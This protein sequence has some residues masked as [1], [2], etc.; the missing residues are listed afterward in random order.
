V[1]LRAG[2]GDKE[3]QFG[4]DFRLVSAA[5]VAAGAT[6]VGAAGRS[7]KADV[8]FAL[9]PHAVP[10]SAHR[11]ATRRCGHMLTESLTCG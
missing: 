7:P 9:A 11:T 1:K 6:S 3:A 8:G 2:A 10:V 4:L 5:D